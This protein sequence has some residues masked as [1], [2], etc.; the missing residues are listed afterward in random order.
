MRAKVAAPN[1]PN[2]INAPDVLGLSHRLLPGATWDRHR[3]VLRCI[4]GETA[5]LSAADRR[6]IAD[7][8][9]NRP[10]PASPVREAWLVCGRRSGKSTLAALL[11]VAAACFTAYRPARGERPRVLLIA[12]DR[13]QAGVEFDYIVGMLESSPSL[14]QMIVR[15]TA[16]TIDL[17]NRV[18]IQVAAC[19]FRSSRGFTNLVVICSEI[20]FWRTDD[21]SRNPASEVLTA[22]RP[23]LATTNGLLIAI[24]SPYSRSGPLYQ[25]H[26]RHFGKAGRVLVWKAPSL[27]MNP[28]LDPSRIE[29]ARSDDPAAAASEWDAEFRADIST[30]IDPEALQACVDTG[31]RERPPAPGV[32]Y[33]A[34]CDPSGGSQDSMT[35]AIAHA[36][37]DRGVLDCTREIIPPFDP[38][39]TV[40]EF[41]AVLRSY[42]VS[43]VTGDAYSGAWVR[44]A[45]DAHGIRY[46]VS[47]KVKSAIYLETLPLINSRRVSVLDDKRLLSQFTGLERR[48]GRGGGRDS[49]DHG[50]SGHDDISNAAAGALIACKVS[51]GRVALPSSFVM[52]L[53]AAAV[54]S[55][56]RSACYLF[57]GSY[58]PSDPICREC[59][60]H[61][62]A[63]AM[64]RK[65]LADGGTED[66]RT[67]AKSNIKLPDALAWGQVYADMHANEE[68]AGRLYDRAVSRIQSSWARIR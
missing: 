15:K 37:G 39:V 56:S 67:W 33:F 4:L 49:V 13:E 48:T 20:S 32:S 19:S 59:I 17:S 52:C 44:S 68:A 53:K 8:T 40:A 66:L 23:S 50:P 16:D 62:S 43:R 34:F 10:L 28:S 36:D 27:V 30:F 64:H 35:L 65:H 58:L 22:I 38:K 11:A 63:Q 1:A 57:S 60:G 6:L 47:D 25:A 3:L 51:L 54:P 31:V 24:S 2:V 29:D 12:S 55:F 14:A 9:G 46:D 45:F 26:E 5:K 41:A 61:Q 7:C 42:R 18:R 21:G